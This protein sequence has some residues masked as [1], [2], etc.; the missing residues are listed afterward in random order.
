MPDASVRCGNA[1]DFPPVGGPACVAV[2]SFA[3]NRYR[4]R[5]HGLYQNIQLQQFINKEF[6]SCVYELAER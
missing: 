1:A 2:H 4:L 5:A 6:I 3:I